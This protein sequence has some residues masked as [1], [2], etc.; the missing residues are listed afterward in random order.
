M[1][2]FKREHIVLNSQ[3]ETLRYTSPNTG[4]S[5]VIPREIGDR[6]AHGNQVRDELN[7]SVQAFQRE[8]DEDV[9]YIVIKSPI[10]FLIDIDKF[11]KGSFRLASYKKIPSI[12]EENNTTNYYE[13]T[14]CL[15]RHAV[16]L[17]LTKIEKYL[18]EETPTGN[19]KNNSLIANIEQIRAATLESFWQEP[20]LPF[21]QHDDNV[22]WEVWLAKSGSA[23]DINVNAQV[24]TS[25]V[26]RNI[27]VA[28]RVLEFPEHSVYLVR[29]TVQ[30]LAN[31]V[32]YSDRLAEIRKPR[33]L[34]DFFTNLEYGEQ[35]DW[36]DDLI[37]RTDVR[38]ANNEVVV[39]LL[40]TGV[41]RSHP[42]LVNLIPE[43]HLD[44]VNPA[45]GTAD[46]RTPDGHGTPMAG[47]ALYGDLSEIMGSDNRIEILHHL[48]SIKLI[49][50]NAPH[51][52]DLYGAVT[53]EAIARGLVINPNFK[54]VVCMAVT[55]ADIVH[56]GRPTSWSSAIDQTLFG[57]IE[58]RN[59]KT[60]LM[61]SS[62][63]LPLEERVNY[64]IGNV[65]F[66]IE[67]PA[68]SYN[69]ITVGSYT[70]KD[71]ID[72]GAFP[73]SEVLARRGAM[74]PCNTTSI[75]WLHEWCK[76]PDIVMEGG[77]AAIQNGDAIYPDSLMLLSISRKRFGHSSPLTTFRDTSASTA[78]AS[79]FAAELYTAYPNLRPE[80]IR[81]L[82]VHSA[83]WTPEMLNNRN[84]SQLNSLEKERLLAHVGYGVPNFERAKYSA[85][86]SLS[87]IVERT[88]K[89]FRL[90]GSLV[91]TDE[92]HLFDLPWPTDVLQ[93]L[94]GTVVK[95]KITL[96]YFIEPNPGNRQYELSAS[97]K[98]HGL[99]FKMIN[100]LETVENFR[101]RI[102]RAERAANYANEGGEQWILGTQ[103][104]DK[105]CIH[106]DIWEG[107]AAD[108]ATRNKIAVYPIGG[109][110][111]TRRNL[112]RYD[113]QVHYSLVMTID[114]P[115]VDTDIYTP[116]Q[117]QIPIEV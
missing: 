93:D 29:G 53:Q 87:M 34:T 16:S 105:G 67:D 111:K 54:R 108:L 9:I 95:F 107:T 79:K 98:S 96:S 82:M 64:P 99:R 115:S 50:D 100:P 18:T 103:L 114:T 102:S 10:D 74:S 69:A 4:R 58:Q 90:E 97:Y 112:T 47:I 116:V 19:P 51:A 55:S 17:F 30:Q 46:N 73:G 8:G 70:L 106:K 31:T 68:Q 26:E 77:N 65:D 14:V 104:R 72:E 88:I 12:V 60:L 44:S 62:G 36:L 45:W 20:E 117:V 23:N 42:L 113:N 27:Q 83:E 81:A 43:H 56:R 25:L 57:T 86:N 15:N 2:P 37:A 28:E 76:K 59:D 110:W 24:A 21:P 39:C 92:F 49:N 11:D 75:G 48:E 61:V 13:A 66:T 89:P 94:L 7:Q 52:P 6:V 91:K 33:D 84:I 78:L 80:T 22:W 109:W 40:D 32:L 1:P 101:G 3:P 38:S 85:N 71:V 5:K 41:N 35:T 63:N